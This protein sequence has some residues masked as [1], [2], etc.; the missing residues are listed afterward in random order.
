MNENQFELF[1]CFFN[2][3]DDVTNRHQLF[4][5]FIWNI[6]SE[7]FFKG[8]DELNGVEG[9]SAKIFDEFCFQSYLFWV[10]AELFNDDVTDFVLDVIC[11]SVLG[12]WVR[13]RVSGWI[14]FGKKEFLLF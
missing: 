3:A 6:D 5:F 2:E 13:R 9:I 4:S 14:L 10:Y 8:H 1:G 12:E 11:H 7:L